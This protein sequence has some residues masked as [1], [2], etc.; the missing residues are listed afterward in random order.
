MV[1][2][3]TPARRTRLALILAGGLVGS[4][5]SAAPALAG[6]A[7]HGKSVFASQCSM[8][9]SPAKGGAAIMGPSLFGIVGRPVASVSGFSYSPSM[10]AYGGAWSED[11]LRGYLPAPAKAV[12]GTKMM[13]AGI[14]NPAQLDDLIA[15][16]ATLK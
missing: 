9:H 8:C 13:F 15:Y 10:K 1:R 6:D 4:L 16:L 12:P 3:L 7:A 5:L 2:L 14:K 11:R